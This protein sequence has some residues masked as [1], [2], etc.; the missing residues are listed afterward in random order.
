MTH[1]IRRSLLVSPV[2]AATFLVASNFAAAQDIA[3]ALAL[4][5]SCGG[6]LKHDA[7]TA[8]NL[9]SEGFGLMLLETNGQS[10]IALNALSTPEQARRSFEH[11]HW[12][13]EQTAADRIQVGKF[14]LVFND[15]LLRGTRYLRD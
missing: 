8:E 10:A 14:E 7:T 15:G 13:Y 11:L 4:K 12:A 2:I 9:C 3:P 6:T 1:H 5:F